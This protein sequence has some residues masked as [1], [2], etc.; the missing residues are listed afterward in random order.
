MHAANY[1]ESLDLCKMHTYSHSYV[2][3]NIARRI[4]YTNILINQKHCCRTTASH[5]GN[6]NN[7]ECCVINI[8]SKHND[9]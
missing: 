1:T 7:N 6:I 4:N 5:Y 9:K 2:Y 3:V 8:K